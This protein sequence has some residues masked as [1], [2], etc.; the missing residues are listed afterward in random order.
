MRLL[1]RS[2]MLA[3]HIR[4]GLIVWKINRDESQHGY[5]SKTNW[6]NKEVVHLITITKKPTFPN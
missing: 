3:S 2:A 1:A 4:P 6:I 5:A